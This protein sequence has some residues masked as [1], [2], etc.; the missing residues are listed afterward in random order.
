MDA[1]QG[2]KMEVVSHSRSA[3]IVVVTKRPTSWNGQDAP[4]NAVSLVRDRAIS[5][6]NGNTLVKEEISVPASI[7]HI[8]QTKAHSA[9]NSASTDLPVLVPS[10]NNSL[11]LIEQT[12]GQ[13]HLRFSVTKKNSPSF[14]CIFC[15]NLVFKKKIFSLTTT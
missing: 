3:E 8:L 12:K 1:K 13:Q 11:I 4:R 5:L 6:A 9:S 10:I 7:D 15:L 2:A 14:F